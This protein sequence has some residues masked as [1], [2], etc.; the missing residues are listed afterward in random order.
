MHIIWQKLVLHYLIHK[1]GR[2]QQSMDG[3]R[4]KIENRIRIQWITNYCNIGEK[5]SINPSKENLTQLKE[6][7]DHGKPESEEAEL[8]L[9]EQHQVDYEKIYALLYFL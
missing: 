9:M 4:H 2:I 8:E 5:V 3:N 7:L 6:L 1:M